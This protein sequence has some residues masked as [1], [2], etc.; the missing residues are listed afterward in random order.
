MPGIVVPVGGEQLVF[1]RDEE[2]LGVTSVLGSVTV[3][4]LPNLYRLGG[5]FYP[6]LKNNPTHGKRA[7]RVHGK[8]VG[9][10]FIRVT[11]PTNTTVITLF[12]AVVPRRTIKVAFY[13]VKDVGVKDRN[14]R[15]KNGISTTRPQAA[16]DQWL[17]YMNTVYIPQT[18]LEFV[19]RPPKT[20]SVN[21]EHGD[22]VEMKDE[23]GGADWQKKWAAFINHPEKDLDADFHL[24]FVRE[25]IGRKAEGSD[26]DLKAIVDKEPKDHPRHCLIED[27]MSLNLGQVLAHEA[28]HHLEVEHDPF[29]KGALMHP[30]IQKSGMKIRFFDAIKMNEKAP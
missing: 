21:W 17:E 29:T 16:V 8:F 24:F 22:K 26:F 2:N 19:K 27:D 12:A 13:F 23:L 1:L 11:K 9:D 4:E 10:D 5:I 15:N 25:V 18:N 20:I 14:V 7:F 28:G 30:E 6:P 3:E